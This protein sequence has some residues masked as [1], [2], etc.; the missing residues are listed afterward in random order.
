MHTIG[1]GE[2]GQANSSR[3]QDEWDFPSELVGNG[4]PEQGD[5]MKYQELE[6]TV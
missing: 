6:Y 1:S 4:T 5:M 2:P 3:L